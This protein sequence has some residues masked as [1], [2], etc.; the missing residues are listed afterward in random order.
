MSVA[1]YDVL[2]PVY[3]VATGGH[4]HAAWSRQLEGLAIEAGLRGQ[5][6]LDLGC[7]TGSS[8]LPMRER[9]YAVT[10]VDLS[11]AMLARARAK[12][13][14][15]V[16]LE[17]A[18]M[19]E[20]PVLGAFDLVWSVADGFNYLLEEAGLVATFAGV[21]RN[22][23]ADGLLVFDVNTLA[24]CRALYSRLLV[25][26]SADGVLIFDGQGSPDLAPD[27]VT[28]AVVERLEPGASPP[29]WTRARAVH[30]QRHHSRST[31]EG[32]LAAAGL[33]CVAVWGTDGAGGSERPLD[34]HRHNKAVYIA[35]AA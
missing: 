3:D 29:W 12:L 18:D 21:R 25:V 10:G 1:A 7:G 17:H 24:T 6:L 11:E 4:D 5:R 13:G 26:P 9:G 31:L 27:T 32:A 22:L 14:D 16:R 8:M 2:A 34:E 33:E 23:A 30:R 20:L 35:R 15:D 28:E 19:R